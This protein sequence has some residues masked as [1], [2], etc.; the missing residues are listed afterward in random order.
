MV[1]FWGLPV[2]IIDWPCLTTTNAKAF[3]LMHLP[4]EPL[5]GDNDNDPDSSFYS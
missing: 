3:E 2:V 4:A 5:T 1:T